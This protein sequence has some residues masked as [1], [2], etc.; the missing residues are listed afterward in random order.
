M[1]KF[2]KWSVFCLGMVPFLVLLYRALSNNLGPDPADT[3]AAETGE[4][5]LRFLLLSLAI[6]P[7][8]NIGGW[9]KVFP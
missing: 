4:W 8:R 6:T 9:P 1:T 2:A 7:L 3:L 5:T